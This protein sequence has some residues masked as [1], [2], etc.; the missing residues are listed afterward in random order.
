MKKTKKANVSKED[1]EREGIK[2]NSK[3]VKHG[4]IHYWAIKE[5]QHKRELKNRE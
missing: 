4:S 5:E 2:K 1:D 3:K